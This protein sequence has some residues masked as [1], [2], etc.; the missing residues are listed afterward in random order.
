MNYSGKA[1]RHWARPWPPSMLAMGRY[2]PSA[3]SMNERRV[4]DVSHFKAAIPLPA[5]SGHLTVPG[6]RPE[7]FTKA[8][9]GTAPDLMI[10]LTQ[11]RVALLTCWHPV[12]F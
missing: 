6:R 12:T 5:N 3:I 10:L 8:V 7:P 9:G 11:R 4:I 2:V 1:A